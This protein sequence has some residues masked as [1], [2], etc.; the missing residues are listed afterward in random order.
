MHSDTDL[1]AARDRDCSQEERELEKA[2][3]AAELR[4]LRRVQLSTIP[5]SFLSWF[6]RLEVSHAGT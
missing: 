5:K 4:N 3:K 6:P 2:R 1:L